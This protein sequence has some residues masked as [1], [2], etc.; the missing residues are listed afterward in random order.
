[1]SARDVARKSSYDQIVWVDRE[2]A[3]HEARLTADTLKQAML[4]TGTQGRFTVY[5]A[6]T[7]TPMLIRWRIAVAYLANLRRGFYYAR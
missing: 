2:G 4:A 6:R 3:R 5:A 1:M 7:A